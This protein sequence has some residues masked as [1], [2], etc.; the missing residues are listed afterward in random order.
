[1]PNSPLLGQRSFDLVHPLVEFQMNEDWYTNYWLIIQI[2]QRLSKYENMTVHG[3]EGV[4]WIIMI[5]DKVVLKWQK[6][7]MTQYLT[8]P[9]LMPNDQ[10]ALFPYMRKDTYP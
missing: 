8:D 7:S 1:M 9:F 2:I 6:K 3:G 5:D 10:V 4:S